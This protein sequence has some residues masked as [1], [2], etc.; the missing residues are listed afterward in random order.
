[1]IKTIKGDKYLDE[2]VVPAVTATVHEAGTVVLN[3][4][5]KQMETRSMTRHAAVWPARLPAKMTP[6]VTSLW[7]NLAI[8]AW[9][10]PDKTALVF[11]GRHWTYGQLMAA[12]EHMAGHLAALGVQQ[13]DRVVLDMQNCPQLVITHFAILRLGAVVVPVNPMNK[14]QELQR[15][16]AASLALS[17][18]VVDIFSLSCSP[19]TL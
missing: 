19:L 16:H 13:G 12:C 10:F 1:M 14:A 4:K 5:A 17:L 15:I 18:P 8:N 9:R 2:S 6:A 7:M 11:M 3:I